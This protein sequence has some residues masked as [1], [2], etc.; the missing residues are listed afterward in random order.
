M[1]VRQMA[2]GG[3]DLPG[4]M[5]TKEEVRWRGPGVP[6]VQNELRSGGKWRRT[7][8]REGKQPQ[9]FPSGGKAVESAQAPRP[10]GREGKQLQGFPSGGK[11]VESAQ[12]AGVLVLD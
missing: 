2:D 1:G 6:R 12:A 8:G 4:G 9:G 5:V 11:A 7:S 10:A 3:G